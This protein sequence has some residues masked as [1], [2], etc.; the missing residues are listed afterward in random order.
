MLRRLL[1]V[2]ALAAGC[3]SLNAQAQTANVPA[4][5]AKASEA[6]GK[7]GNQFAAAQTFTSPY[8]GTYTANFDAWA[9]NTGTVTLSYTNFVL[10]SLRWV[11]NGNWAYVGSITSQGLLNG[12]LNGTLT[13]SNINISGIQS[14]GIGVQTVFANG[15]ATLTLTAQ[16]LNGNAYPTPVS[17]T[18]TY[19]QATALSLLIL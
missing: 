7:V 14:L 13:I 12:T 1:A 5:L 4:I 10:P 2:L 15:A 11:Y 16:S 3:L 8:G 18:Y 17:F 6:L 19:D 9:N